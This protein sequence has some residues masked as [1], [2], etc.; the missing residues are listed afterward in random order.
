MWKY[1]RP[2]TWQLFEQILADWAQNELNDTGADRYGRNGQR[3]NGIDI[4]AR[5]R[6]QSHDIMP[7]VWTIQAKRYDEKISPT[8]VQ[9]DLERAMSHTPRPDVF[10]LATTTPRDS[11]LQDWA[12]SAHPIR[13][14]VW[15]WDGLVERLLITPW[16]RD[17]YLAKFWQGRI[18]RHLPNP[19]LDFTGR[20]SELADMVEKVEKGVSIVVII[21]MGGVG[22][23]TLA[24]ALANQINENYPDGQLRVDLQGLDPIRPLSPSDIMQRVIRSFESDFVV[25][26]T[27]DELMGA[28]RS[29]LQE[30]R[31]LV[32]FDNARDTN[33]VE[34]LIPAPH[35]CL[36]VTSRQH[37]SLPGGYIHKLDILRPPE[38]TRFLLNICSRINNHASE[39]SE[40][41][42]RLPLAL[43]LAGT[44]LTERMDLSV[45]DYVDQLQEECTRRDFV[46]ATVELSYR[47]LPEQLQYSWRLLAVFRS[48]FELNAAVAVL[49]Q[50]LRNTSNSLG[51]L[52][53]H[54]MLEWDSALSRYSM[55]E[56]LR[57]VAQSRLSEN[58]NREAR[59][60]HAVYYEELLRSL[61]A[62]YRIG[63]EAAIEALGCFDRDRSLIEEAIT[64]LLTMSE[65]GDEYLGL[66]S[67]YLDAGVDIF[68]I[69]I[70]G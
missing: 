34:T 23:T 45:Q 8:D 46:D 35:S 9:A 60:N 58:E 12:A 42:G 27:S 69:R 15:F 48:P 37:I 14:E 18:P 51:G 56:L 55:H 28:Y 50:S 40:L 5:N 33:Q 54:S 24:L 43:R 47:L 49:R 53:K 39:I 10:I 21:G 20:D 52:L 4:L 30:K 65:E 36:I 1:P 29:L 6:K 25:P 57:L 66:C 68:P 13:V 16:F 70:D 38:S 7:E 62:K 3:Q 44:V 2:D 67:S 41:C 64:W 32:L 31:I 59:L 63:S 61:K 22:K 11:K 26:P 19:P 17:K